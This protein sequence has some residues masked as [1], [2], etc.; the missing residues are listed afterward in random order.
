MLFILCKPFLTSTICRGKHGTESTG[1][2]Q[3]IKL[4]ISVI[5][6]VPLFTSVLRMGKIV[7]FRMPVFSESEL[8]KHPDSPLPVLPVSL[9]PDGRL[10]FHNDYF[11]YHE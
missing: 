9:T 11:P 6:D 5:T 8:M 10:M 7:P 4:G 3:I 2:P 1:D